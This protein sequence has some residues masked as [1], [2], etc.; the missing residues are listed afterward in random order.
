MA[1][2]TQ[3][4]HNDVTGRHTNLSNQVYLYAFDSLP[5]QRGGQFG[6]IT[7]AFEA[8]G[9]L[10]AEG[11]NAVL[12]THALTGNSHA[13]D[14]ERP[15]N[16]KVAWWNPLIGPGRFFDTSRY[17]II[18]SNILGS[19]YGTTGPS[20]IEPTTGQSYGM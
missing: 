17:F 4:D 9:Q 10:N 16:T 8:W 15:D 19:C 14:I 13:H 3:L 5:L 20:S 12:I 2:V 6:P 7:V 11:D 18:C 1:M